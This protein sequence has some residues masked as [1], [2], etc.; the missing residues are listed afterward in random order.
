MPRPLRIAAA[1]GW[2]VLVVAS[3]LVIAAAGVLAAVNASDCMTAV[4]LAS[5]GAMLV[6]TVPAGGGL[7]ARPRTG[8]TRPARVTRAQEQTGPSD[9]G[10]ESGRSTQVGPLVRA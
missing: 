2:R 7:L 10:P 6:L 3:A 8:A 1:V 4:V 5:A 9:S